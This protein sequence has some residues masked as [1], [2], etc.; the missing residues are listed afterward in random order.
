MAKKK[1]GDWISWGL[2]FFLFL[3]GLSPV[4]LVLLLVKLF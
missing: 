1:D 2:I 4:A 3:I